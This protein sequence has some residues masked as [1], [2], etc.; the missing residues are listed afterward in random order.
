MTVN[1]GYRYDPAGLTEVATKLTTA[2]EHLQEVTNR[3]VTAP[4]AGAS[5]GVVSQAIADLVGGA[6]G[7]SA[8]AQQMAKRVDAA[9]GSYGGIENDAE[10]A[11]RRQVSE[12]ME[13]YGEMMDDYNGPL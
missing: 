3:Q 10:G 11:M 12:G 2:G 5:S 8:K 6:I 7:A 13:E 9:N 1:D 4:D